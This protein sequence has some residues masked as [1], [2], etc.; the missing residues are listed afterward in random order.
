VTPAENDA[1]QAPF[2]EKEVREA[3][4]SCYPEGAPDPD[5]LP[6]LFFQK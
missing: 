1:L 4:F 6:F 5:G 2:E 3:A